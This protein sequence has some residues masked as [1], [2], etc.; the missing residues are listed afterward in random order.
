MSPSAASQAQ[1]NTAQLLDATEQNLRS[2]TR[3]LNNDEQ[4]TVSQIRSYI[5]Q[6]RNA[7]KNQEIELAHNL[8]VKAHQLADGLLRQ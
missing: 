8:A 3:S 5:V 1:Q 4:N 6:A 7:L 2:L